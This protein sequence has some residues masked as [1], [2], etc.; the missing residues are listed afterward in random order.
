MSHSVSMQKKQ[1][2]KSGVTLEFELDM[3][4]QGLFKV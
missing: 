2:L 3:K 1:D 4:K